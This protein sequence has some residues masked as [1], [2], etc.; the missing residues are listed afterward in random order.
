MTLAYPNFGTVNVTPP[1]AFPTTIVAS[2]TWTSGLI[3]AGF[4]SVVAA[5]TSNHAATLEVQRY[6]DVAGLVPVGAL[7]SQAMSAATPAWVGAADALPYLTFQVSIVN[8]AGGSATI[9]NCA[10]L[11]GPL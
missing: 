10:I 11:T 7:L 6:A 3:V 9:T 5:A 1:T 2:G 8:S 4:G